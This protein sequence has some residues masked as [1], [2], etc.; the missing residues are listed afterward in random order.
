[1]VIKLSDKFTTIRFKEL[2]KKDKIATILLEVEKSNNTLTDL[3]YTKELKDVFIID[4][5]TDI[6]KNSEIDRLVRFI[7]NEI[8]DKNLKENSKIINKDIWN[9]YLIFKE[10]EDKIYNEKLGTTTTIHYEKPSFNEAITKDNNDSIKYK[11]N[12]PKIDDYGKLYIDSETT[13]NCYKVR[14]YEF[15]VR[16]NEEYAFHLLHTIFNS[17]FDLKIKL[18]ENCKKPFLT[19]TLNTQNCLRLN[20]RGLTCR[21]EKIKIQ[22]QHQNDDPIKHLIKNVRDLYENKPKEKE[23]FIE[24]LNDKKIEYF[25]NNKDFVLWLLS[26]YKTK[27]KRQDAIERL[28]LSIYL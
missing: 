8:L 23:K 17:G 18:C 10:N 16:N 27:E 13:N 19:K 28:G 25:N 21:Y 3:E 9:K 12:F 2:Y 24:E 5:E 15:K 11:F 4:L 1:M 7:Y 14:I 6:F 22:K 26:H 20:E